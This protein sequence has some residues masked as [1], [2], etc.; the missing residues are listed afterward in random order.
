MDRRGEIEKLEQEHGHRDEGEEHEPGVG[1][2]PAIRLVGEPLIDELIGDEGADEQHE[3]VRDVR[4]D[5]GGGEVC[6]RG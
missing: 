3:A 6:Q 4:R 2:R 5:V 1:E